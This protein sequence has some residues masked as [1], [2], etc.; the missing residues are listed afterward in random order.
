MTWHW[1]YTLWFGYAWSSDK[2]N[3]PEA[4]QQTIVYGLAAIILIPPVRRFLKFEF[5]KVHAKI[6]RGHQELHE[7]LDELHRKVDHGH[8]HMGVPPL[9]PKDE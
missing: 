2:G 8:A 9:P 4:I 3:G 6:D 1:L 7:K 5:D